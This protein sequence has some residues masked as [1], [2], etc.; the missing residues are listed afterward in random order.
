[1][2]ILTVN[3]DQRKQHTKAESGKRHS[4]LLML[5]TVVQIATNVIQ[6]SKCLEAAVE[7]P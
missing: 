4:S 5:N 1:M 7:L 2:K 6:R 3:F